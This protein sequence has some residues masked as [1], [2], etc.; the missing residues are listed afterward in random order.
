MDKFSPHIILALAFAVLFHLFKRQIDSLKDP[1]NASA[2]R[3][4]LERI[5]IVFALL[6]TGYLLWMFFV[7]ANAVGPATGNENSR[8]SQE[9]AIAPVLTEWRL[10]KDDGDCALINGPCGWPVAFNKK[11][12]PQGEANFS[13]QSRQH[14]IPYVAEGQGSVTAYCSPSRLCAEKFSSFPSQINFSGRGRV[15]GE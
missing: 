13:A 6:L 3:N 11:H 2:F 12:L 14:C 15:N 10:C 7:F 9:P 4:F 5:G 8:T 1:E